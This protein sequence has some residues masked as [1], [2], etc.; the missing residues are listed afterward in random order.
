MD[1]ETNY[2]RYLIFLDVVGFGLIL[3]FLYRISTELTRNLEQMAASLRN[4]EKRMEPLMQD[5]TDLVRDVR[6]DLDAI[7]S[8][9][10]GLVGALKLGALAAQVIQAGILEKILGFFGGKAGKPKTPQAAAPSRVDEF[11]EE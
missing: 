3:Y 6:R 5:T 7:R 2:L 1:M 11:E 4:L 9:I 8:A 10:T